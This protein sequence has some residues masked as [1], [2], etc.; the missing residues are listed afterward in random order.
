MIGT[1]VGETIGGPDT[2]QG[3]ANGAKVA[4]FD[5]GTG[6]SLSLAILS[7][8]SIVFP[9]GYNAGARVYS[10]SWYSI[11]FLYYYI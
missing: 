7:L 8:Y 5:A 2:W 9:L 3:V 11:L 1:L 4:F 10:N 6:S